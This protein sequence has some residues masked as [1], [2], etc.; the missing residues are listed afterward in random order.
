VRG[1]DFVDPHCGSRQLF[2]YAVSRRGDRR[3]TK[4]VLLW[5]A[6]FATQAC[7]QEGPAT[8]LEKCCAISAQDLAALNKGHALG[9]LIKFG[10][11]A[12]IAI[13]GAIRLTIP[14][15]AYIDWYR[16]VEN[17][18]YSSMIKE[19]VQFHVPPR[20][21]DVALFVVDTNQIKLLKEC[22][23]GNCGFKF[24]NEEIARSQSDLDWT[25][26]DVSDKAAALAKSILLQHV[27][28]YMKEGNAALPKY[29]DKPE[30]MNVLATFRSILNS[31]PYVKAAFPELFAQLS[32]YRGTGE[33]TD[34]ED[35]VY[36]SREHYGF[37][38]KSFI[39][40]THTTIHKASPSVI[41]LA[42]KQIWASHYYDGSLGITV[43]VDASPGTY[44]VYLNRSRI[45][46]LH[47]A[48]L[49][50][51]LVKKFAPGSI[52]KEV[53]A[54]KRQVETSRQAS[55]TTRQ[56]PEAGESRYRESRYR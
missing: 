8:V 11:D 26:Q 48:G 16:R 36:W 13:M 37:G 44:L 7:A 52:R 43:L 25:A 3:R 31:S 10:D 22:T 45:D 9:R 6:V 28:G 50:R 5:L 56:K 32:G 53:I 21:E 55:A 17:Y 42:A 38:L 46:L 1:T 29:N 54:L 30:E 12:D 18:K 14:K 35:I 24:S 4:A 15:G 49:K 41:V 2:S 20:P 39:N 27:A 19:A 47:N 51:W 33:G 40:V 23:P 34:N